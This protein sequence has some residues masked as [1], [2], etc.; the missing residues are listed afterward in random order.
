MTHSFSPNQFFCNT[1]I[2]TITRERLAVVFSPDVHSVL[3]CIAV[4]VFVVVVVFVY[5]DEK[6]KLLNDVPIIL[7]PLVGSYLLPL[8]LS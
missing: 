6:H 4:V 1:T 8:F 5:W 3:Y 2:T 7:L